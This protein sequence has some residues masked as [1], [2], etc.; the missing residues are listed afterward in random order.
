MLM[1]AAPD[2]PGATNSKTFYQNQLATGAEA[3][4]ACSN[5][6]EALHGDGKAFCKYAARFVLLAVRCV[7]CAGC[8]LPTTIDFRR[9][10]C[11]Y[12]MHVFYARVLC[13]Y[14]MH[15]PDMVGASLPHSN[16][17]IREQLY[18]L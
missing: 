7:M 14:F 18:T 11:T 17:V 2:S 12:F 5:D 8:C 1:S 15:S 13:T 6:G 9:L 10:L 4:A 16:D 3:W